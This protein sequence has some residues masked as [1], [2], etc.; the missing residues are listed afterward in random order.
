MS[1]KEMINTADLKKSTQTTKKHLT[2][3]RRY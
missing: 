1:D 2:V 3:N